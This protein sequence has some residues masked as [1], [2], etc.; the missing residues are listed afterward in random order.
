MI[1]FGGYRS[2]VGHLNETW[3]LDLHLMIWTSP[4]YVGVP[5]SPR[6][7][8]SA[9]IIDKYMYVSGG[10]NGTEHLSDLHVLNV[11][12]MVWECVETHGDLPTPRRQHALTAVGRH[13]VIYGGYNGN[14]Y[15]DDIYSLDTGTI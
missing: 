6:R 10:Y 7:G 3:F 14:V 12:R 4:D 9:A 13:L 8:H 5:P 1:V 2:C 15:L 11:E